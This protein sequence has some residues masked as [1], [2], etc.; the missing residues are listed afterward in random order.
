MATTIGNRKFYGWNNAALLFL[1]QFAGSGFVYFAYSA[2]F[3][4]MIE[5]MDWNR[6]S[7]SIAHSVSFVMLGLFYPLT[8]W[9]IGKWGVRMTLS[10][11]LV[12]MLTG[13]LATIFLVSQVWHWII[14]WGLVMGLSF[15]LTGPI[16][17]QTMV[18]HWFNIRRALVLGIFVTG[19]AVGGVVAQPVLATTM[20]RFGSWQSGWAT[21]SG[22]VLIAL[23]LAQFLINRPDDIGQH[24]D[25]IHPADPEASSSESTNRPRTYRSKHN[26]TLKQIFRSH[27][28]YLMMLISASYLGIGVFIITHGALHLGDIG[29]SKLQTVLLM[30]MFFLGSVVGRIPAGALGDRIELRWLVTGIMVVFFVSF[31]VFSLVNSY[32]ILA[33]SGCIAGVCYGAKFALA[34]AMMSNY[35]G[36][37]SFSKINSSFAPLLLPFVA[38]VPTGSG[39]IY[40]ELGSYE[41]AFFIGSIMLA[42]ST[43]AAILLK[44][45]VLKETVPQPA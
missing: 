44:P 9:M 43:I 23:I 1:I 12:I 31:T 2:V 36:A 27:S 6:G 41:V 32:A 26:W 4:A 42:L 29:I 10:T 3:P 21:S 17:G 34:P 22:V 25:N 19:G 30:G 15:S 39:Y 40:E 45:P 24:P 7:A 28:V 8:A 13:L 14:V 33:V 11:G 18:I 38:V 37:E 35:F 20:E 5:A 16:C